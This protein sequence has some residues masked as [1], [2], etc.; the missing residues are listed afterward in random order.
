MNDNKSQ[1]QMD[2]TLYPANYDS[3]HRA[4]ARVGVPRDLQLTQADYERFRDFILDRIGLDFQEDKRVMLGRGLAQVMD[5]IGSANLDELYR[6]LNSLPTTSV[7]WDQVI[8]VLTV[9][10]TY[11]FRNTSHFDALAKHI[12]PALVAEREHSNRRIRIWSAGCASG[13]EPYS[14]AMLLN[15]TI[16]N[17]ESWNILILA[18]DINREALKKAQEGRYN[19]WSFRGVEKHVQDKYF[20]LGGNQFIISDKIKQMVSFDYL[21]LVR[22]PFPSLTNNTNAMDIVLCRNVTIY[23]GE[24]TTRAVIKKF[25]TCVVDGGWLIPGP[26]EPNMLYYTDFTARN[27]PGTVIYQKP[28]AIKPKPVFA[29]MPTL[30]AL[31]SQPA[32][33]ASPAPTPALA[34][35][36]PT[37]AAAKTQAPDL[38]EQALALVHAGNAD[39]ALNKLYAKIDENAKFSPAYFTL[40]KIYANKGNLEE[41]QHWCERAIRLD[42]MHPEPY[43]TLSMVY[44]QHG[45]LDMAIEALKKTIY[46]DREFV[47][48][49][50]NLAQIYRHQG[51]KLQSRRELQNVQRLLQT[52]PRQDPVPEGDGLIVARLLELVEG[53]LAL[54]N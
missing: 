27:F 6:R 11:F 14:L 48:A 12:L 3:Y 43:Y 32:L 35:T 51:D 28:T 31:P 16:P 44:Q 54:D 23:F 41:A 15:E 13:E 29:V 18:T 45:L 22:D 7:L 19:A 10:E 46:L 4:D 8:G 37:S 30:G 34:R 9:G 20:R 47:L 49:H 33:T 5:F 21:N 2:N 26:S 17:L 36:T 53:E 24:P 1:T 50:Y 40:G 38:Y 25:H 39:D 52:K 42:K